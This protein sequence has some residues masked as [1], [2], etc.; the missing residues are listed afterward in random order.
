M[1]GFDGGE[2]NWYPVTNILKR[3][4]VYSSTK[5]E[6]INIILKAETDTGRMLVSKVILKSPSSYDFTAPVMDCLV[7]FCSGVKKCNLTIMHN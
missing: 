6:N 7:W 5:K 1:N 3:G 2:W 4:G